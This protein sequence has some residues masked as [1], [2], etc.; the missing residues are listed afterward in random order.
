MFRYI[1]LVWNVTNEQQSRTAESL[2]GRLR[3]RLWTPAFIG[4]GLHVF[5]VAGPGMLRAL[6]L[7]NSAG[8]IL[9]TLF[10]RNR[11]IDDDSPSRRA[12]PSARGTEAI[13]TSQGRWLIENCWGNYVALLHEAS[14]GIVR[15]LKDPSGSLPC[16]KTSTEDVTIL[17]RMSAIASTSACN[18]SLSI[19]RTS[20]S[21]CSDSTIWSAIHWSKWS[22]S[23]V[24]SA[25][26]WIRRRGRSSARVASSRSCKP[27]F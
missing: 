2:D 26:S 10:E 12:T 14:A 6:P 7:P 15:V 22:R 1:A 24:A 23:A 11:D 18:D 27:S 8:V 25:S 3:A 20:A 17:F 5:C 16:F 19:E 21:A 4:K 9:G 13:L